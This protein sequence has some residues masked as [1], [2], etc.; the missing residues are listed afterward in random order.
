[1]SSKSYLVLFLLAVLTGCSVLPSGGPTSSEL[2]QSIDEKKPTE[3]YAVFDLTAEVARVVAPTRG[4]GFRGRFGSKG[5]R[6]TP[7]V[8]AGDVLQVAIYE[9]ALGGLFTPPENTM[10]AANKNVQL[11]PITVD[12]NG[13]IRIPYAGSI[14]VAGSTPA[15]IE[16]TIEKKLTGRAID[17]QVVVTL[18]ANRSAMVTV[19]GD[20]RTPNRFP[21][22][23]ANERLLDVI[24][25]AGGAQGGAHETQVRLLRGPATASLSLK[26]VQDD[27]EENVYVSPGDVVVLE[28]RPRSVIA[29]GASGRNAEI[30]FES[31]RMTLSQA[32]GAAGGLQ[33][34]RADPTGVFVFRHE[35]VDVVRRAQP[36][37]VDPLQRQTVPTIYKLDL[38]SADG[39]F[40]AQSF[41]MR[42][43]DQI[44]VANAEGAQYLKFLQLIGTSVGTSSSVA[45]I[46]R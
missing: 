19:S 33:D 8:G 35:P 29:L 10:G 3:G 15:Q 39:Y 14:K 12:P 34:S 25:M 31:D 21:V 36:T 4:D 13:E 2:V 40:V 37:Y 28:K 20:V 32:I 24:S 30:R 5:A 42:D 7:V 44:F 18:G 41:Q 27:P 22:G 1:M 46:A 45:A 6:T 23:M 26:A 9:S 16:R 11:P 38:R 43:Q 17:P